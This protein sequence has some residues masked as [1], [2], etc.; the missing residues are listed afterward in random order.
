MIENE[1]LTFNIMQFQ[2]LKKI[3]ASINGN[4]ILSG[5]EGY[6]MISGKH[7]IMIENYL[8]SFLE[9][10]MNETQMNL[11]RMNGRSKYKEKIQNRDADIIIYDINNPAHLKGLEEYINLNYI[12]QTNYRNL[13]IYSKK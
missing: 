4:N 1:E 7:P 11:Y 12:I 6:S 13:I 8:A 9:D 10:H 3:T 5:W 2:K